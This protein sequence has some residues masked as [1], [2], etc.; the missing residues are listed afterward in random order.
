MN[1]FQWTIKS[2][3]ALCTVLIVLGGAGCSSVRR[4]DPTPEGEFEEA[5]YYYEKGEYAKAIEKFKDLIYKYPGSELVE[6]SRYYLADSYYLS[7]DYILA[8]SEFEL[9]NRE[10]PQ[11][12]FADIAL[13]KAGLAYASMSRRV[14]RDQSETKKAMDT[15]QNLLTKYPNTEYADTVRDHLGLLRDKMAQKEYRTALFYYE[16]QMYDSAII[17]LKSIISNYSESTVLPA[18][19][20]LLYK[21]SRSMGYPDDARD[22]LAWLCRDYPQ[23]EQARELCGAGQE[24]EQ[25]L[26]GEPARKDGSRQ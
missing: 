19:L 5:F 26:T 17:Y 1:H 16:A 4:F 2:I 25:S 20:Y 7:R 22:A 15:F 24:K 6:Q 3:L 18:T 14:E 8:S 21:A 11:G 10:F 23:S 13:F 9:L 12:Q